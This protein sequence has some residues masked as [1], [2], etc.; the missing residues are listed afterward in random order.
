MEAV[1]AWIMDDKNF[2][3]IV[4]ALVIVLGTLISYLVV[5]VL[6]QQ[7]SNDKAQAA[8]PKTT[9][10]KFDDSDDD[11]D[12][13]DDEPMPHNLRETPNDPDLLYGSTDT[14]DWTQTESEVEMFVKLDKVGNFANLRA[15]DIKAAI[16]STGLAVSV[17]G[18]TLVKGTFPAKVL[19]DDCTWQLEEPRNSD[20]RIWITLY[21]AVPTM[22]NQHWKS[23]LKGDAEIDVSSLGPPVHGVDTGDKSSMKKAIEQVWLCI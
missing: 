5:R 20:K 7:N 3:Q 11:Y 15:K 8:R 22:R 18:E 10:S 21:K 1:T 23:A 2:R 17:N 14:Y 9:P 4:A 12:F 6:V 13:A 16:T 19:A